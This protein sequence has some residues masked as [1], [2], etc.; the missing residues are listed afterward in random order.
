MHML[1]SY[2]GPGW[3]ASHFEIIVWLTA[4]YLN[5]RHLFI[6]HL[7]QLPNSLT[8][9]NVLIMLYIYIMYLL[10]IL[11]YD[12]RF[13]YN[14]IHYYIKGKNLCGKILYSGG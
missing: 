10:Y 5:S 8:C 12:I 11:S 4:L 9:H 14:V 6:W 1:N 7:C 13:D 3:H 2:Y